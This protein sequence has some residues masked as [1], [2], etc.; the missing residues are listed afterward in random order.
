LGGVAALDKNS[1]KTSLGCFGPDPSWVNSSCRY[2]LIRA[3][4]I[5]TTDLLLHANTEYVASEPWGL[6]YFLAPFV[7][8]LRRARF[9]SFSRSYSTRRQQ[10]YLC[11]GKGTTTT[12]LLLF[13]RTQFG[14]L[15][16]LCLLL[17]G[18]SCL[19]LFRHFLFRPLLL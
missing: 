19:F 9:L 18:P 8:A 7:C 15:F 12:C 5:R 14:D 3:E 4:I 6:R 13:C 16:I 1:I 17:G 11:R 2:A 10:R